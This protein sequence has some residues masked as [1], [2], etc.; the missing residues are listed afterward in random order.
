MNLD[1][2][3]Q[4]GGTVG[5]LRRSAL[6]SVGR[7]ARDSLT[8]DTDIT[9]RLLLRGWKTAY[10]NRSEC[11]EEVP[12]SWPVALRQDRSL[13]AGSQ[14]CIRRYFRPLLAT[15]ARRSGMNISTGC[16]C[17]A[18]MRVA[19]MLVG[20]VL[21]S[22]VF[23]GVSLVHW[24]FVFLAVTSYS[25]LADCAMVSSRLRP[26]A[27]LDGCRRRVRLLPFVFFAFLVSV[28]ATARASIP[29]W[30][31]IRGRK[32]HWHKTERTRSVEPVVL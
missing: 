27:R 17:S 15:S 16:S 30:L 26:P 12:E 20:W 2:V 11:Y 3:P 7:L 32:F 23:A 21:V 1:L 8:E 29:R 13:G 14:R 9:Y 10:Q 5:G 18:C 31:R 22:D 24:L 28:I 4:V 19:V 6:A 25:V